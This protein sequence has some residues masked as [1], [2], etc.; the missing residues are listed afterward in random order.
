MVMKYYIVL[1]L[2]F[3]FPDSFCHDILVVTDLSRYNDYEYKEKHQAITDAINKLNAKYESINFNRIEITNEKTLSEYKN[4]I[5]KKI[6]NKTILILDV[7][8][9]STFATIYPAYPGNI[10]IISSIGTTDLLV[11][12]NLN[13]FTTSSTSIEKSSEVEWLIK[14]N[15]YRNIYFDIE[16]KDNYGNEVVKNLTTTS[17]QIKNGIDCNTSLVITKKT[18]TEFDYRK[19]RC[20]IYWHVGTETPINY[21]GRIYS[22]SSRIPGVRTSQA[23]SGYTA[24]FNSIYE[25]IMVALK[26]CNLNQSTSRIRSDIILNLRKT[27]IDNPYIGTYIAVFDRIKKSNAYYNRYIESGYFKKY[28]TR[29]DNYINLAESQTLNKKNSSAPTLYLNFNLKNFSVDGIQSKKVYI[30]GFLSLYTTDSDISINDI[31][32]PLVDEKAISSTLI[33]SEEIHSGRLTF[34]NKLYKIKLS[35]DIDSDL[36]EF[37]FD[38]QNIELYFEPSNFSKNH[39]LSSHFQTWINKNHLETTIGL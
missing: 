22:S 14:L 39:F 30:E 5:S 33:K 25:R 11:K 21:K 35:L 12:S 18:T 4:E 19:N 23:P 38:R 6:S 13:I 32:I 29:I 15:N 26:D 28:I 27:N 10:A 36:F 1:L 20:D 16:P 31:S 3:Y 34:K 17:A 8:N 9:S 2:F 37:P 24:M 7:D